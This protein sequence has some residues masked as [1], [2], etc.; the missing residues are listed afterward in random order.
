MIPRQSKRVVPGRLR[1]TN[2]EA[3]PIRRPSTYPRPKVSQGSTDCLP[4]HSTRTSRSHQE[5][6]HCRGR[7]NCENSGHDNSADL[8]LPSIKVFSSCPIFLPSLTTK[9]WGEDRGEGQC[10]GTNAPPL[11][12]PLLHPMEGR[13]CFGCGSTA[14]RRFAVAS[15]CFHSLRVDL[16]LLLQCLNDERRAGAFGPH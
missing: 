5:S 3:F 8:L 9:E 4:T 16:G 13:S 6:F 10:K 2:T 14:S 15:R 11:P 12:N 1:L 7:K